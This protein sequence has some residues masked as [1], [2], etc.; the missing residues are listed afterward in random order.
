MHTPIA[1]G[2]AIPAAVAE[3]LAGGP[4]VLVGADDT[5]IPT[6]WQPQ[7]PPL[8]RDVAVLIG[9]SGSTGAPKGVLLTRD[10]IAASVRATHRRLGGAGHWVCP[11]PMHYVAGMMTAARAA[12]GGGA[13][14]V[15]PSELTELPLRPGR[16]YLSVVAAQ[17][18][19]ALESDAITGALAGFDAILVGGS[20]IPAGLLHRGREAG[21]TLV[22]TYGMA[23][24]C[25]GCVYA[26]VPLDD[27]AVTIDDDDRISL[28]GPMVF[29]GYR[30]DPRLT[31]QVLA[32]RTLRTSDRGR[33]SQGRLQVLGRADD[34]VISGGSNVDLAHVQ[35]VADDELGPGVLAVLAVPDER[36]GA[37]IVAL[38]DR[39]LDRTV[40]TATLRRR[41]D[42]AAVPR[43]VRR[44]AGLP[45]TSTGKIDRR[46]L[47][48]RWNEES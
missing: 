44:V 28:S 11:L 22:P 37:R 39:D 23:E 36:W 24:T 8:A 40:I 48:Q 34:V 29:S 31:E 15:V 14:S 42:A 7:G 10:A 12:L 5:R 17:L 32:G 25:G 33:W 26:G 41:L 21:L 16:N 13:L 2:A 3:A 47:R 6:G 27:V 18:H 38:T 9:T 45:R 30:L 43:E 35:R 1:T 4:G 46:V 20:A 19:R